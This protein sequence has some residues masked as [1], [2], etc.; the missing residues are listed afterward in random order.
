MK[1]MNYNEKMTVLFNQIIG[2]NPNF[3][4]TLINTLSLKELGNKLHGDTFE[5][6]MNENVNNYTD[7]SSKHVGKLLFR[8]GFD[9]DIVLSKSEEQLNKAE[10]LYNDLTIVKNSPKKHI[11]ISLCSYYGLDYDGKYITIF[12]L[13]DFIK[14]TIQEMKDTNNIHC[15]S[16]KCFG[17]GPLQLSTLSDC[18]LLTKLETFVDNKNERTELP[19]LIRDG[20][21]ILCI[22]D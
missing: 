16:L 17:I 18:K 6:M 15:I 5:I 12:I 14:N 20:M 22:E 9:Y 3:K 8:S 1:I 10:R 2:N 13:K 7:Y 11:L 19:T 21:K 4:E